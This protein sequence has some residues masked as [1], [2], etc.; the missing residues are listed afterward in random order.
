MC[1]PAGEFSMGA[2]ED[3]PLAKDHEKPQHRVY[4]DAYWIDR[5]E[6]TNANFAKCVAAGGCHPR[7]Y[8]PYRD[9]IASKTRLDYYENPAFA[10][11]PVL[12][13]DFDEAA[14]YCRWA[15][16]RLPSEAEWEKAA[17]GTD[18]RIFPWGDR[19]DC[20][21][22]SYYECSKDT[23]T[24]SSYLPG[25]SPYGALNMAGNVW[26]WVADWYDPGYYTQSPQ[27]NP[28]GPDHGDF[29]V[30]RGGGCT[31]LKRDLRLTTRASGA[32]K[33]YFD[34]QMGFRCVLSAITSLTQP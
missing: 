5:S 13:Y 1:V 22:A 26:E 20:Q 28:T 6:V 7:L 15:G 19:L 29:R 24:A 27:A 3:D 11:F 34:G 14:A 30:R 21:K 33:H 16:R 17:R 31:S 10:D 23:S 18:T 8:T 4:L 32:P 25:A 2:A 9:G 12:M